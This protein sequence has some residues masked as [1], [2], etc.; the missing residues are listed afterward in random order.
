MRRAK[1]GVKSEEGDGD[2]AIAIYEICDRPSGGHQTEYR[3]AQYCRPSAFHR[4][5]SHAGLGTQCQ[6][7]VNNVFYSLKAREDSR[8]GNYREKNLNQVCLNKKKLLSA[9]NHFGIS[10]T[11][12]A[13]RFHLASFLFCSIV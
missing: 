1:S 3:L 12:F 2:A 9:K 5:L 11:T 13:F 4:D 6:R 7:K 10:M 8:G